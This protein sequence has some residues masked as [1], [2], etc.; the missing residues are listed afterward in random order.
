MEMVVN[1]AA[2]MVAILPGTKKYLSIYLPIYLSIYLPIYLCIY[3]PIYLSIY[4][5]DIC[6]DIRKCMENRTHVQAVFQ[7]G[8]HAADLNHACCGV[9][10][11]RF[12]L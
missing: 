6:I 8:S 5:S 1:H 2:T 10:K 12:R 3:L 9:Y 11:T 4:L 7:G